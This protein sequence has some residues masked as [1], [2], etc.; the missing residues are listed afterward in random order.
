MTRFRFGDHVLDTDRVELRGPAGLIDCE[1]QV[2]AVLAH[3]IEADG[4][5]VT[6]NELLDAVWGGPFVSES[7]MTTRIKQARRVL[8]DDGRAQWAI[9]TVHGRGYRFAADVVVDEHAP[10]GHSSSTPAATTPR[11]DAL[12]RPAAPF[13]GRGD[14]LATAVRALL[15]DR[16]RL[17]TLWGPGGVG[18]TRLAI[19][20]ARATAAGFEQPHVVVDGSRLDLPDEVPDAIAR[21]AG[22]PELDTSPAS[23]AARFGGAAV[24]VVVDNFEHL[25]PAADAVA[26]MLGASERIQF[27]VTSRAVL[28]LRH[29]RVQRVAP[30]H[31]Q[32]A[33]PDEVSATAFLRERALDMGARDLTADDEPALARIAARLDGL[34][35][36]L[37]LAAARLRTLRP[38]ALEVQ[39][40]QHLDALGGLRDLPDRHQTL[41]AT[42]EWSIGLLDEPSRDLL[43]SMGAFAGPARWDAIRVVHGGDDLARL[44][45]LVDHALVHPVSTADGEGAFALLETVRTWAEEQLQAEGRWDDVRRRHA[46]HMAAVGNRFARA[47]LTSDQAMATLRLS[48]QEADL[49]RAL[50]TME[51]LGLLAGVRRMSVDLWRWWWGVGAGR[52]ATRWLEVAMELDDGD[53]DAVRALTL[54]ATARAA[55]TDIAGARA[56]LALAEALP[57]GDGMPEVLAARA[58]VAEQDRLMAGGGDAVTARTASMAAAQA[59]R[60]R[61]DAVLAAEMEVRAAFIAASE[62]DMA[63]SERGNR[64]ALPVLAAHGPRWEEGSVR[65]NLAHLALARGDTDLALVEATAA[66]TIYDQLPFA[67]GRWDLEETMLDIRIA[68]GEFALARAAGEAAMEAAARGGDIDSTWTAR[69]GLAAATVLDGE[70]EEAAALLLRRPLE[71]AAIGNRWQLFAVCAL[72]LSLAHDDEG[73]MAAAALAAKYEPDLTV[74]EVAHLR[75]RLDAITSG[76]APDVS[77]LTAS[78][79]IVTARLDAISNDRA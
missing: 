38:A 22:F 24:L 9:K 20:V 76:G 11:S 19:E 49:H 71:E 30:L 33:G 52:T 36:A 79:A 73:A 17:L 31:A 39:V 29:E 1:P 41:R 53:P 48:E 23:L 2:F 62:G 44:A 59:Y 78:P 77:G 51:S 55:T 10:P 47:L 25:L 40:A 45:L 74:G 12:Q 34:P 21:G 63:E 66:R 16:V 56:A 68:R 72:V 54:L 13:L 7:A 69:I 18:K 43:V 58:A 46:D 3:L 15:D 70:A 75:A 35:L 8:G 64:A 67:R 27:L 14:D 32:A 57:A 42:L 50:R 26:E 61:G 65:N 4:D 60:N 37:E 5:L 28:G 6:K